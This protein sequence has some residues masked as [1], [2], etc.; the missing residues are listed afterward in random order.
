MKYIIVIFFLSVFSV[1]CFAQQTIYGSITHD[2][3]Q[4]DYILYV[5]ASY[6]VDTPVPLVLNFHGI[7]RSA[8]HQMAYGDFRSIADTAGFLIVHPQGELYNGMTHWNVGG[9]S[10]GSHVDDVG[11]TDALI[12]SLSAEYN[13]DSTMIYSAGLSNGGAMSFLLA[14]QLSDRIAAIASVSATMTPEIYYNCDAH[15]PTPI[16]QMHGT[17]DSTWPY[18][19]APWEISVDNVILFWVAYNYCN[20]TPTITVLP[21]IDPNDGSTVELFAYDEGDNGV[22]ALHYKI[23]G[24]D[25]SWPGNSDANRDIDA[26]EEIWNFFSKYD[27]NGLIIP[28]GID[29]SNEINSFG[30]ELSGNYPNPFNPTTTISFQLSGVSSQDVELVIYNVKGQRIR[31]YSIPNIQYSITNDKYSVTWDGTDDCN[32]P[33]SAGVYFYKLKVGNVE[34]TRKMVLLK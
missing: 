21:D 7:T 5:P 11:F 13:I 23:T 19:G 8:S 14:C 29:N 9:F 18:N 4:R 25:H 15:H 28:T 24:G 6:T 22:S 33:V 26:S 31:K 27:I 34:K 10:V 17:T 3:M 12:D 32:Q 2:Q 30:F 1:L 20:A 16:L